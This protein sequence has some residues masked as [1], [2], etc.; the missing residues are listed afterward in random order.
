MKTIFS[1]GSAICLTLPILFGSCTKE[2][3]TA[4]AVPTK[5]RVVA[6]FDE[7]TRTTLSGRDV[8]WQE[9]D[10]VACICYGDDASRYS[11]SLDNAPVSFDGSRASFEISTL[12]G[13]QPKILVSP[14][15]EGCRINE[16]ADSVCLNIP[17]T[18]ETG[19]GNV[20][21]NSIFSIGEIAGDGN[22][23]LRNAVSFLRFTLE[24]D[25]V[26]KIRVKANGGEGLSGSI[27]FKLSSLQAGKG[28]TNIIDIIPTEGNNTFSPG[29]YYVPIPSR[30][31]SK[32]LTVSF[33]NAAGE[34][35]KKGYDSEYEVKRNKFVSM[36]RQSEWGLEFQ[37][38]V[39]VLPIVFRT[40]PE[41]S[42][43]PFS[44]KPEA[45]SAIECPKVANVAGKGVQG[46]F[47]LVGYPNIPFYFNVQNTSGFKSY[48]IS[49]GKYGM[50]LGGTPGDYI[51]IPAIP[52]YRLTKFDFVEGNKTSWYCIT[53]DVE[54]SKAT[55]LT[56]SDI[57]INKDTQKTYTFTADQTKPGT[58]YRFCVS[59]TNESAMEKIVLTY[60][61]IED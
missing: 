53:D 32:G 19:P 47:Y 60:E 18:F 27:W 52:G 9:G 29:E 12:S 23:Q 4:E 20:P 61:S 17:A 34:A 46:P 43:F 7:Y 13:M 59:R 55:F 26:S 33:F 6:G 58:A 3:A 24:D 44:D 51:S 28:G 30:I 25:I 16:S 50:R 31:Y 54:F 1:L 40:G 2:Q 37:A 41:E 10:K 39:K 38:S 11:L 48:F 8:V 36:G 45:I 49:Q 56:A 22:V 5:V 14:S 35:A 42:V 15:H 21:S 57:Q